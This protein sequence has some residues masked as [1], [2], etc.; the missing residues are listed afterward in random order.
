MIGSVANLK[1]ALKK[2]TGKEPKETDGSYEVDDAALKEAQERLSRTAASLD[3]G[4]KAGEGK[5]PAPGDET[6]EQV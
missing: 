4:S 5:K 3:G 1:S 6:R 2:I